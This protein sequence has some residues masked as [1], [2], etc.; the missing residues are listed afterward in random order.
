MDAIV[1]QEIAQ[2]PYRLPSPL[3]EPPRH[4]AERLPLIS[5]AERERST[6]Q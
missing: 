5:A 3:H 2:R 4:R 1:G 6:I